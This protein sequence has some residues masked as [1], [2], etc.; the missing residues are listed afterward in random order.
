M[1]N[2]VLQSQD[3]RVQPFLDVACYQ[4]FEM[5]GPW[6]E[7]RHRLTF[8]RRDIFQLN[9]YRLHMLYFVIVIIISS[10]IVYGE[11]L[12]NGATEINGTKLRYIDAL[13]LCCSAMTTTGLNTVNLGALTSFQQAMLCILMLIGNLIFVST[14]VVIIRRHFFRRKLADVVGHSEAGRKV[15]RNIEVREGM[16]SSG[17][18]SGAGTGDSSRK[19][20]LC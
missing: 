1:L 12:A 6:D 8:L 11:G 5:R 19:R 7:V 15:L 10:V 17:H 13:F 3:P 9:F 2:R 18:T 16:I 4:S 14:F 20:L